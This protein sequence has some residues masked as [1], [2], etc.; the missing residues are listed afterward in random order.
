MTDLTKG[1]IKKHIWNIALPASIGFIFDTLYNVTDTVFAGFISTE[2]LAALGLTFPAFFFIIAFGFGIGTGA[3]ALIANAFGEKDNAKAKLYAVQSISFSVLLGLGLTV[4]GLLISPYMFG[5]LGAS[6]AYLDLTLQYMD[7]IFYG[8]VFIM[9]TFIFNAILQA[10]GDTVTFRNYLIIGFFLNL[11]INPLLLWGLWIFPELGIAGIAW[12]TVI[13]EMVGA[14]YMGYKVKRTGILE[15]S[16]KYVMPMRGPFRELARQGFPAG[17]NMMTV[18]I[19]VFV[20][21]FFIS[22]FGTVAVA[23][24]GVAAKIEQF[25]LLPTIGLDM[26]ALTIVGQNNGARKWDRVWETYDLCIKYG[27]YMML[28]AAVVAL[29]FAKQLMGFFAH[30]P[31]VIRLG[32]YYVRISA[33]LSFAYVIMYIATSSLQ[34]MKKPY[35][36]VWLG[37][38]RQILAPIIIFPIAG[39]YFGVYGIYWGTAFCVWSGALITLYYM[40]RLRKIT[41]TQ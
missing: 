10:R 33:F 23:A 20:I 13:T 4:L 35:Y 27:I 30:E 28:A 39:M 16:S 6:G 2:A 17:L 7:V 31:E 32:V 40:K 15:G 3:T 38:Y 11:I 5:L 37:L 19:G 34:G 22:K 14:I 26:A 41:K 8:S 18:A 1:P 29:I 36:A 21:T 12:A 9:L 25:F 24:F